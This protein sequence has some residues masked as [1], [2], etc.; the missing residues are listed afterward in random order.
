[1]INTIVEYV[2][3]YFPHYKTEV[4]SDDF[5]RCCLVYKYLYEKYFSQRAK[6]EQILYRLFAERNSFVTNFVIL[7]NHLIFSTAFRAFWKQYH[8]GRGCVYVADTCLQE[9][10][11]LG[12]LTG[13]LYWSFHKGFY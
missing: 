2:N 13:I 11:T 3:Y 7:R 6:W 5:I 10:E 12:Y 8:M 1:M 4:Y 9:Y